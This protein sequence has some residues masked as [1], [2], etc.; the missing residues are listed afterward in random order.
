MNNLRIV[1]RVQYATT[2]QLP[3]QVLERLPLPMRSGILWQIL[4]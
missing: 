1:L 4:S 2:M 3:E